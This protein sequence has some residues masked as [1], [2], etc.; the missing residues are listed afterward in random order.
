MPDDDEVRS[1]T[2]DVTVAIS[3]A[4]EGRRLHLSTSIDTDSEKINKIIFNL[5]LLDVADEDEWEEN[6]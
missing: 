5:I 6:L 2:D 3:K 1:D 4:I